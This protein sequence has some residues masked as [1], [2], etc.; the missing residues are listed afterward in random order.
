MT[1]RDE[2]QD[3]TPHHAHT[4]TQTNTNKA[5]LK[6]AFSLYFTIHALKI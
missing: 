5:P 6:P 2:D 1:T 3:I 4:Y